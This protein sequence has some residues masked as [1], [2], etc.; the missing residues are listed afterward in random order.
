MITVFFITV[1]SSS[2]SRALK[3]LENQTEEF[4]LEIIRDVAPM[5]AAF[6]M[7]LD[8]CKTRFFVQCDEDMV[9]KRDAIATLHRSISSLSEK[10]QGNAAMVV[11]P[12]FDVH[13]SRP[14][15][16]I[17]AYDHRVF[18]QFPYQDTLSCEM[19]Q[20]DRVF[21]AGYRTEILSPDEDMSRDHYRILGYHGTIY[22]PRE[23]F[24]RY[25]DLARKMIFVGGNDWF[26]KWP[27]EFFE[28]AA[29]GNK[30]LSKNADFWA[31]VGSIAGICSDRSEEGEKDFRRYSQMKGF[32]R[33]RSRIVNPPVSLNVHTTP[34]CNLNCRWCR[35]STNPETI[36]KY[37]FTPEH[38]RITLKNWPSIRS[39]CIAGFGEP[40][41]ESSLAETVELF[42]DANLFVSLITNGIEV[43]N[44]MERERNGFR[45][46]PWD[47]FGY[48]NV[49]LNG[50]TKEQYHKA[51]GSK[52]AFHQAIHGLDLLLKRRANAGI[53]FVVHQE[54]WKNIP[55]YLE[56]AA[57][58]GVSFVSLINVLPHHD[59]ANPAKND[60]FW[61]LVLTDKSD[62]YLEAV[63]SHESLADEL[64]VGVNHW[65]QVISRDHNPRLCRSPYD[66]VGVGGS[67]M[68]TA[69][70]RIESPTPKNGSI[71]D[72]PSIWTKSTRIRE[73]REALCG[74]RDLPLA[75]QMCFGN[76][77][78]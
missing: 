76:W 74:A 38:A 67:C 40:L 29:N 32:G 62:R 27:K 21:S 49:S 5:S 31:F 61:D 72:G 8:R 34:K 52:N 18:S 19:D 10:T 37:Y 50:I 42:F 2:S 54:N 66:T 68:I 6:Q 39:A 13:L 15:L 23:A 11:Y 7:M 53:S 65:P 26:D 57:K 70:N 69:C 44:V 14:I 77:R 16:G 71:H 43:E 4:K 9:L 75:C 63:D 33:V 56:F 20:L 45:P 30:D 41:L 48:V 17:K 60:R 24:E 22:T 73:L 3:A 51:T 12:L 47:R 58:K 25:R 36:D 35:R 59:L 28:R 1:G 55:S 64:G 78:Y 46:I